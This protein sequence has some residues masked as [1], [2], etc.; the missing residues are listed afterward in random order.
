MVDGKPHHFSCG[1]LYDGLFLLLDDESGTY[2]N[3]I[4]GEALHGPLAGCRLETW[5]VPITTVAEALAMDPDLRVQ[6]SRP[7]WFGRAFSGLFAPF[8]FGKG[9][10]P[11]GFRR[12]LGSADRRLPEFQP[13]LG[14]VVGGQAAFYPACDLVDGATD[15]FAGRP[16]TFRVGREGIPAAFWPDLTRPYQLFLRWYGFSYCFPGCEIRR[17][18]ALDV[19]AEALQG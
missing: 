3:H 17:A 6:L 13:G 5:S 15:H 1:G 8:T 19:E 16:L 2:W 12:T 4:T 10:F 7:G 11:P 9:F 18:S 14:V